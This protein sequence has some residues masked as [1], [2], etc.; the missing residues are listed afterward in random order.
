MIVNQNSGKEVV[1][2]VSACV[3]VLVWLQ[4]VVFCRFVSELLT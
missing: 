2:V 1:L 4:I 3:L